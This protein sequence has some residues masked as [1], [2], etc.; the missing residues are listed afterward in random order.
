MLRYTIDRTGREPIDFI[1]EF[2][3]TWG[4]D[5]GGKRQHVISLHRTQG[6]KLVAEIRY[7][8]E[9]PRESNRSS[10]HYA[11]DWKD[12]VALLSAYQAADDVT[13]F[14]VGDQF[15]AN[16]EKVK[17]EIAYQYQFLVSR[18]CEEMGWMENID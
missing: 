5:K 14:P 6:G 15:R 3:G 1:G 2:I 13:G 10:A 8:T 4:T 18:V 17:R 7:E 16:E 11:D 9:W 12:I